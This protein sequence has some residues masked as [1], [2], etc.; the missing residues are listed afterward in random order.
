MRVLRRRHKTPCRQRAG[1]HF[2]R[3]V[4]VARHSVAHAPA[5]YATRASSSQALPRASSVRSQHEA[6]YRCR[7][8]RC[9][10]T[11]R[12]HAS[13]HVVSLVCARSPP[14][15]PG[16]C[17]CRVRSRCRCWAGVG[18]WKAG[19]GGS[20]GGVRVELRARRRAQGQWGPAGRGV[21]N[22]PVA[23]PTPRGCPHVAVAEFHVARLHTINACLASGQPSR[24]AY[25][26]REGNSMS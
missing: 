11:R 17:P 18:R 6:A 16:K 4:A 20:A 15:L 1:G 3:G 26:F 24:L 21:M 23:L 22:M 13:T 8:S 9:S 2:S 7:T 10:S 25:A 14:C 12:C 5:A 19:R